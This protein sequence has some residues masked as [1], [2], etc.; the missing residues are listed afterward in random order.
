MVDSITLSISLECH[1]KIFSVI[2]SQKSKHRK[3]SKEYI[4]MLDTEIQS[5]FKS[6]S[7]FHIKKFTDWRVKYNNES[8]LKFCL[9]NS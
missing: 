9:I 5:K 3:Y 7:V 2:L 6:C 1:I 8:M 4:K